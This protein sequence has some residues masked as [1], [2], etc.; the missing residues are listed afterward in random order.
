MRDE[1]LTKLSKVIKGTLRRE[2]FWSPF[3]SIDGT[4]HAAIFKIFCDTAKDSD[5]PIGE[6]I[7]DRVRDEMQQS[8]T[9]SQNEELTRIINAWDE[10]RYIIEQI[11]SHTPLL[12]KLV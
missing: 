9:D 8:L 11:K 2:V 1:V 10:W 3:S 6:H 4:S 5:Q 12:D 7:F